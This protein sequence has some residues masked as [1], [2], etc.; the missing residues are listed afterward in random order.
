M[1]QLLQFINIFIGKHS[2]KQDQNALEIEYLYSQQYIFV[3][4][5]NFNNRLQY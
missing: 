1:L 4:K 2:T 5:F 3:N